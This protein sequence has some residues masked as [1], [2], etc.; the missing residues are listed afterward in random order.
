MEFAHKLAESSWSKNEKQLLIS[1]LK[2]FN[3]SDTDG[4]FEGDV[5]KRGIVLAQSGF[6]F[7]KQQVEKNAPLSIFVGY[8]PGR[9]HLG[10]IVMRNLLNSLRNYG[11]THILLGINAQES[12][13]THRRSLEETLRISEI[14]ERVLLGGRNEEQITRIYDLPYLNCPGVQKDY[15]KVY[16][17]VSG[18]LSVADFKKI[19]GWSEETALSEY[20]SLLGAITGMMYPSAKSTEDATLVFTDLKHL[21]F[22]RLAKKVAH[23]IGAREPSFLVTNALPS[24][25][26]GEKRM[27]SLGG[28]STLYLFKEEEYDKF[29]RVR[30]GGRARG[31][32]ELYGGNPNS[33]LAL[34]IAAFIINSEETEK[35]VTACISGKQ[36]SCRECKAI[37]K[38]HIKKE[39]DAV[40]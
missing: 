38:K 13:K 12:M 32:Q 20:I 7:V 17:E 10:Y 3:P 18:A 40:K 15:S 39:G 35:T 30:T 14:V 29:S 25:S 6:D 8:S 27:S 22:V 16:S 31:E 11:N 34:N 26:D 19:M 23:K 36:S 2:R 4:L 37:M 5:W 21:P 24:L 33:C 9:S 1:G 28:D